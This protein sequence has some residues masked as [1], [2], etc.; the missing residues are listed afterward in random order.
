M[1]NNMNKKPHCLYC[2]SDMG[3]AHPCPSCGW[4][5]NTILDNFLYLPAGYLLNNRY[6]LGCRFD[7]DRAHQIIPRGCRFINLRPLL[8]C[9]V[10]FLLSMLSVTFWS[11]SKGVS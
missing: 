11:L 3:S 1:I 7:S 2:M 10:A 9:I 5:G 4:D 8:F 6:T